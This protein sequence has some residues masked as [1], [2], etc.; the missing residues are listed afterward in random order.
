MIDPYAFGVLQ[1]AHHER[2]VADLAGYAR[3]AGIQ[4][5]WIYQR[6]PEFV[7][8]AEQNY[9]RD[10]RRHLTEGAV[11]GICYTGKQPMSEIVSR[12]SAIAGCLTRNFVRARMA[13]T[14][15][16]I[17]M[18]ASGG[19]PDMKCLLIPNFHV[20]QDEGGYLSPWQVSALLDLILARQAENLQTVV[21][22]PSLNLMAKDYGALMLQTIEDTFIKITV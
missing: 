3:D 16:V 20:S 21:Y 17:D 12:M 9:L 1:P 18:L 6:L 13:T 11:S 10:F 7:S 19:L 14:G 15:Q 4:P 8:E 5:H 2:L 22:A